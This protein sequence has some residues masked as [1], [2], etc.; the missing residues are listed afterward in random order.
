MIEHLIIKRALRHR[1]GGK[2]VRVHVTVTRQEFKSGN[3]SRPPK[4]DGSSAF[5]GVV[6]VPLP[7]RDL[8]VCKDHSHISGGRERPKGSGTQQPAP[9]GRSDRRP[10]SLPIPEARCSD[11][12]RCPDSPIPSFACIPAPPLKVQDGSASR[13]WLPGVVGCVICPRTQAFFFFFL[14]LYRQPA[15]RPL[16][17]SR[18]PQLRPSILR[19]ISPCVAHNTMKHRG[20]AGVELEVRVRAFSAT[21]SSC[22]VPPCPPSPPYASR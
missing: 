6:R 9:A 5:L 22:T 3:S 7:C 11:E 4:A 8:R 13:P 21:K 20:S 17:W 14:N 2:G 12:C 18:H 10:V 1:E 16:S 19:R 15:A